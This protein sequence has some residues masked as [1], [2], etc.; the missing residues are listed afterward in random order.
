[1]CGVSGASLSDMEAHLDDI[2]LGE[3]RTSMTI[4]AP[5]SMFFAM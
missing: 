4:N 5:A 3:V 1:M 2:P